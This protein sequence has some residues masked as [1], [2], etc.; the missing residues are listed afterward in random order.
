MIFIVLSLSLLVHKMGI[1]QLSCLCVRRPHLGE[2]LST[3]LGVDSPRPGAQQTGNL[4]RGACITGVGWLPGTR[5][6]ILLVQ[7]GFT[8]LLSVRH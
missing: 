1:K 4:G 3:G 6:L 5:R 8:L 7:E 2:D